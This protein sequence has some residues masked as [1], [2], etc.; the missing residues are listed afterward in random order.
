MKRLKFEHD[1]L[2]HPSN[3]TPPR[4]AK[5]L[6]SFGHSECNMLLLEALILLN[7]TLI[8]YCNEKIKNLNMMP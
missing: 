4:L 3:H 8:K 7:C 1:A 6:R 5:A 2:T